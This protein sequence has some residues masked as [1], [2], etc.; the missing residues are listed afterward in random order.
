MSE[1][2]LTRSKKKNALVINEDTRERMVE[3]IETTIGELMII[4]SSISDLSSRKNFELSYQ[5]LNRVMFSRLANIR[6]YLSGEQKKYR[7]EI[8]VLIY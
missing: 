5:A 6:D 8:E 7:Q 2:K 4:E 3:A 1:A